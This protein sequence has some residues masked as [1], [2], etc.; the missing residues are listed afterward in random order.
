M[1]S[2]DRLV[3]ELDVVRANLKAEKL[4]IHDGSYVA[5]RN[6]SRDFVHASLAHETSYSGKLKYGVVRIVTL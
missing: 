1:S 5:Q 6:N 3:T 2:I 4:T